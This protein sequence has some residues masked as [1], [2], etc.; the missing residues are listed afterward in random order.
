VDTFTIIPAKK[1]TG[2]RAEFAEAR[3]DFAEAGNDTDAGPASDVEILTKQL[4]AMTRM[5]DLAISVSALI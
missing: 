2:T 3:A 4:A 1:A 5:R